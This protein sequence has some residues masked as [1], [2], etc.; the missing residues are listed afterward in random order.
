[1]NEARVNPR[2]DPFWR[3]KKD[4]KEEHSMNIMRCAVHF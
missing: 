2:K 4:G 1:M 3:A